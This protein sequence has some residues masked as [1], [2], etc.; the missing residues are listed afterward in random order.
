MDTLTENIKFIVNNN[1][2]F[3]I[4]K[5]R[6]TRKFCG[7]RCMLQ[8]E[9]DD[10]LYT[11]IVMRGMDPFTY[12]KTFKYGHELVILNTES[13]GIDIWL[14]DSDANGTVDGIDAAYYHTFDNTSKISYI[15]IMHKNMID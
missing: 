5:R 4:N 11:C 6:N 8:L 1:N 3:T 13:R 12:M 14:E 7:H 10:E 2:K 15:P 9:G